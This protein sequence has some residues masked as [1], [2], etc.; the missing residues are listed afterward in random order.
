LGLLVLGRTNGQIADEL[1]IS[2]DGAKWHV[3]EIITKLGVDSREEAAEYWR[4]HNGMRLRFT[5][6][7]RALLPGAMW[8]KV[9]AAGATLAVVGGA[10]VLVVVAVQSGSGGA[11]GDGSPSA[12]V[13]LPSGLASAPKAPLSSSSGDGWSASYFGGG[14]AWDDP[15]LILQWDSEPRLQI[16]D[17]TSGALLGSINFSYRPFVLLRSTANE[18]LVS[19]RPGSSGKTRLLVFDTSDA[20]KLR[21]KRETP[22]P[23]RA[24]Y[25]DYGGQ[26]ALSGNQRYLFYPAVSSHC[27]GA[28]EACDTWSVGVF[29]LDGSEP[30]SLIDLPAGCGWPYLGA[31]LSSDAGLAACTNGTSVFLSGSVPTIAAAITPSSGP[32]EA[33]AVFGERAASARFSAIEPGGELVTVFSEGSVL[34]RDTVGNEILVRG[35]PSDMRLDSRAEVAKLDATH[36]LIP[37][38]KYLDATPEGVALFNLQTLQIDRIIPLNSFLTVVPDGSSALLGLTTDGAL[39]RIQIAGDGT[40]PL[41]G[42]AV[43]AIPS[44]WL[45]LLPTGS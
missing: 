23:D 43:P 11:A 3:S 39:V 17:R 12:T 5:R 32:P 42:P 13:T 9:A 28:T 45:V 19:D 36:L 31:G 40:T 44:A 22:L 26:M 25:T 33:E 10:G 2:L 27:S 30:P 38:G 4:A 7:L 1:G 15:A 35:V 8:A 37:Y 16:I 14:K 21:L 34:V 41:T 20:G 18:L 6:A 29:D 24:L